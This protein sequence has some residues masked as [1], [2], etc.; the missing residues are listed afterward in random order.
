[1]NLIC[2]L[3][4]RNKVVEYTLEWSFIPEDVIFYENDCIFSMT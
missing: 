3:K 2:R 1:M 4:K